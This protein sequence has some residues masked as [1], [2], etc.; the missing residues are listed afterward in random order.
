MKANQV[1][2]TI[3]IHIDHRHGRSTEGSLTQEIRL[4]G[5]TE[6]RLGRGGRSEHQGRANN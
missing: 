6:L 1:I 3:A 5:K 4:L 2:P